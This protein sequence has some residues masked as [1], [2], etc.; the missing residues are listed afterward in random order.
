[1]EN[2]NKILFGIFVLIFGIT[3][4]VWSGYT[5]YKLNYWIA[6]YFYKIHMNDFN[7]EY[8][9][10]GKNI[11]VLNSLYIERTYLTIPITFI[12]FFSSG[13]VATH[14]FFSLFARKKIKVAL[15]IWLIIL[16]FVKIPLPYSHSSLPSTEA[17]L[18]VI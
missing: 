7:L 12:L 10:H 17:M 11:W 15:I 9:T 4:L 16:W 18:F 13:Y 14:I 1:M 3:N 5:D 8:Q 6:E 2:Y